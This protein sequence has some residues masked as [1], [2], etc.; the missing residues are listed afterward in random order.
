MQELKLSDPLKSSYYAYHITG[1]IVDDFM[2]VGG[3]YLKPK[4]HTVENLIWDGWSFVCRTKKYK[5]GQKA[6]IPVSQVMLPNAPHQKNAPKKMTGVM[7]R[8]NSPEKNGITCMSL[9]WAYDKL[10]NAM[11]EEDHHDFLTGK[12]CLSM[13]IKETPKDFTS[14][15]MR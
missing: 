2:K 4:V 3:G 11:T 14:H 6:S 9:K 1:G 10:L 5:K 7:M 8:N 12:L 15:E 13:Q